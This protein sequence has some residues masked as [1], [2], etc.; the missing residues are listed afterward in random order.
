[1]AH[2]YRRIGKRLVDVFISVI[3]LIL[4]LPLYLLIAV[5]VRLKLGTP[6]FFKQR[7]PGVRA[8]MFTLIKFR[9]MRDLRSDDGSPL[10]DEMRL[11]AFGSMLRATSLDELPEIWN[12][13]RG[14]MSFIG[15][16][17]L[18]AEYVQLYSNEQ[19]RRLEVRP[20]IT[21]WAQVNGRNITSWVERFEQDVWYVDHCSARLDLVIAWKTI[22]AVLLRKNI[23]ES[24]AVTRSPFEG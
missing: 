17:P 1:M 14:E 3:L 5:L 22:T 18:L 11:T 10:P 16:R 20:G 21:G 12:V 7:R 15:P 24:A 13:L 4:L 9:S 19:A 2:I 23:N 6:V 8:Q